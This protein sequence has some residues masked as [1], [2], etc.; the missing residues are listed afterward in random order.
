MN[1]LIRADAAPFIGLGHLKRMLALARSLVSAGAT[2][3][4]VSRFQDAGMNHCLDEFEATAI[5]LTGGANMVA[6]PTYAGWLGMGEAADAADVLASIGG[7]HFNWIIVDH[8]ALS[9][10]W[11]ERM[12]DGN[13]AQI[14]V[15]DDLANRPLCADLIVDQN[16]HCDHKAKYRAVSQNGA[17]VLGGPR[18]A[19]LDAR[20]ADAPRY[21][22]QDPV[23]SIGLFMGG[24]DATA[25]TL[26]ALDAIK[27]VGFRGHVEIVSTTSNST[28]S[29]LQ[30][31]IANEPFCSLTLDLPTLAPF[32]ARHDVQIGA[33]G[34]ATWERLCIGAPVIVVATAPNQS[35]VL[36]DLAA[37]D[38][39]WCVSEPDP[40]KIAEAL[41]HALSLPEERKRMSSAGRKLVDGHGAVRVAVALMR[42][43]L[44]VR[45]ATAVDAAL[46][47]LW[48]NHPSIRSTSRNDGE[49]RWEDHRA[50]H[51][52]SLTRTDRALLI[53]QCGTR[54]V[55][56]VRYDHESARV[57]EVSIYLDPLLNG[58]GLGTRL[59]AAGEAW[60]REHRPQTRKILAE[61]LPENSASARLFANSG[62]APTGHHFTKS[63]KGPT[64]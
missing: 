62:Y 40:A 28:L 4:F 58:L 19:M 56:V 42:D 34:S 64:S 16:A 57:C 20:Y 11:Q 29:L 59:L 32:F 6:Q 15:V 22:F 30:S 48:R 37:L 61:T 45:P 47:Y 39:A 24:G 49:I 46:T 44:S 53:G 3:M 54:P 12:R 51:E 25:A 55:G 33:A 13:D 10:D 41:H 7:N 1:I 50:W 21:V 43:A 17:R 26:V 23:Q 27:R 8:Y 18:F 36:A 5:F 31:R 52:A 2:V 9:A 35:E 60:L 14:C 38:I 63:L